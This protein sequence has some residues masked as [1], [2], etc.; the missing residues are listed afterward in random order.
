MVF[1]EAARRLIA[2]T[3]DANKVVSHD[4]WAYMLVSACG[5]A[6]HYDAYPSVRYRQHANNLVGANNSWRARM[7]R[8][9]MLAQGRFRRWNDQNIEALQSLEH[10]MTPQSRQTLHQFAR[11]RKQSGLL[12]LLALKRSGV[13]RQTWASHLSLF[14]A[15]LFGKI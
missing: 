11:A 13:R 15:A 5:G 2:Q 12:S 10:L 1:N 3:I 9:R 8:L 6:V 7:L 4:W 14:V